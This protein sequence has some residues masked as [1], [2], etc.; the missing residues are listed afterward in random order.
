MLRLLPVGRDSA[1]KV[2]DECHYDTPARRVRVQQYTIRYATETAGSGTASQTPAFSFLFSRLFVF[3]FLRRP[4]PL[5]TFIRIPPR[6]SAASD[7]ATVRFRG[8]ERLRVFSTETPGGWEI[9]VLRNRR[10]AGS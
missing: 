3:F 9:I 10:P 2:R 8:P 1:A 7:F 6:V 5:C 4:L